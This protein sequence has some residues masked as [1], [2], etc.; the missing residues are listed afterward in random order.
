M[1]NLKI[2]LAELPG[3]FPAIYNVRYQVFQ[4]EQGVSAA[5]EFDGLDDQSQHLLAYLGQEAIG[6]TRMRW[7]DDTTVKVE[8]VA[9]LPAARGLGVGRQLMEVALRHLTEQRVAI[10]LVHAQLQVESFYQKLGFAPEGKIFAE[11]GI[12]HVKMRKMLQ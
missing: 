2:R 3:D 5:E 10:V 7:L 1:S 8:R 12:Q 6:T 9:V 11:A 4:V